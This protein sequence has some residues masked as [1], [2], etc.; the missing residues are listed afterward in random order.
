MNSHL[1]AVPPAELY[2][3]YRYPQLS[4]TF[5]T[6]EIY[7]LRQLGVAVDVIS[8][9]QSDEN[10]VNAE[11]AG[12]FRSLPRTALRR[13]VRDHLWFALHHWQRYRNFLGAVARV[14]DH[15]SLALRRLPSEARRL[16]GVPGPE[17][18]HTHFAWSTAS[19]AAYLARLL[20]VPVSITLHAKDIYVADRRHLRTQLAHFDR[21]VTVCNYNVGFLTGLGVI[22]DRVGEVVVVPC[23]V[24]VPDEPNTDSTGASVEIVSVGRLVEKKGFDT[25]IRALA[26]VRDRLPYIRAV[27]VG[28][29]PERES[30]AGLISE[31][32]LERNVTLAGPLTHEQTLEL[33]GASKLFCLAAQRA[34]DG[35]CDALPV[36][37]REAMAR[38]IPVVSTSVAGIPEAI[39][40]EVG[41]LVEPR[42]PS[43]LANAIAA[44]LSDEAERAKRGRAARARVLQRWTV[45]AQA[46]GM[47]RVFARDANRIRAGSASCSREWAPPERGP[48]EC[49]RI[50][51]GDH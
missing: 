37:L 20:G 30:L 12:S 10:L 9:E 7:R 1:G 48:L 49:S 27:I 5:V 36:V 4:Q 28:E 8:I 44:A 15:W 41:W 46:A 51:G 50:Y 19:V 31:L 47:L 2:V 23:G 16:L 26:L 39:D 25:L 33:M 29:G 14:H 3:L 11:W 38:G 13:A 22:P 43:A 21:I 32:G 40:A 34:R 45:Q 6:N 42:A 17:W 35:D 18:C 24:A